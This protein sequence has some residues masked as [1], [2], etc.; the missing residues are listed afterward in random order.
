MP[1]YGGVPEVS[2]FGKFSKNCFES[3]IKSTKTLM[4]QTIKFFAEWFHRIN[5]KKYPIV[6]TN[7]SK[8]LVVVRRPFLSR[9]KAESKKLLMNLLLMILITLHN[10][11]F[12]RFSSIVYSYFV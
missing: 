7:G 8:L 3:L 12:K 2:N 10:L 4:W 1:H 9:E 11:K 5:S 6:L